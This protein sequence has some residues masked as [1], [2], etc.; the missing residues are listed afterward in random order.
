MFGM[1]G[2]DNLGCKRLH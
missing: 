2:S 1:A